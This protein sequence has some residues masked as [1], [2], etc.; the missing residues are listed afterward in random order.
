M[1]Y[2]LVFA[3]NNKNKLEEITNLLESN[4]KLLSLSDIGC[5]DKIPEDQDTLEGNALQKAR[6][7]YEKYHKNCFADDTGLEVE[8]LIG[9]PGVHSARYSED[10]AP[11]ISKE[12]KSEA[13]VRKLIREMKDKKNRNA[14]F[15]TII[16][17]IIEGNNFFFEGK[18]NGR[19]LSKKQGFSGFGYDPI[20]VP[21]GYNKTYAEMT[22]DEKNKISHRAKAIEKLI[23]YLNRNF[24][25]SY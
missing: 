2:E 10:E 25:C 23:N 17:L 21:S 22:L 14:S 20:F 3:T 7:I 8:A 18:V 6:Y 9:R 19:I 12:N 15:R 24:Y 4:I 11:E 1:H 13:N 5:F 16:C